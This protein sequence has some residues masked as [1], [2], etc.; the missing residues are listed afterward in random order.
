MPTLLEGKL[1]LFVGAVT[2]IGVAAIAALQVIGSGE[3]H[4]GAI[5]V[6][7]LG[8]EFVRGRGLW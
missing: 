1:Q 6:E 5:E 2:A 4:V 7:V 8:R 3:D